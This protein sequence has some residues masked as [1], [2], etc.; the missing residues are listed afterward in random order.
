M[1]NQHKILRV[2]QLISLLKSGPPKSI[3]HLKGVLD[4]SERTVYRYLDL[5]E[6]VGF[7]VHRDAENRVSIDPGGS[8][9]PE[10]VFSS[11]EARFVRDLVVSSGRKSKLTDSVLQKLHVNSDIEVGS[12]LLLR[13]R[14][15]TMVR[16]LSEA[17]R[18][19]KQV[20]LKKYHSAN[21]NEISDRLVEPIRFTENY[22]SLAAYEVATGKNKYFNLERITNVSVSKKEQRYAHKHR[23]SPPDVFGFSDNGNRHTIDLSLSLRAS[24][25]LQEEYPQTAPLIKKEKRNYRFRANVYDLK[26]VTRFVL[27]FY[28]EVKVNGSAP[29]KRHVAQQLLKM[30]DGDR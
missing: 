13:A 11:E 30:I 27:G 18:L 7:V 4:S 8:G 14:L 6:A 15:G 1:L 17:I 26:P 12:T 19:K 16:Q 5:L 20:V 25:I 23:F 21:S 28:G 10:L 3:S 29:F 9:K 24:V 2:L 22:Q